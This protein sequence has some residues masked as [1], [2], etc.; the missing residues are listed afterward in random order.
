M[1]M[2]LFIA[3]NLKCRP[4]DHW[5]LVLKLLSIYKVSSGVSMKYRKI[6]VVKYSDDW[7]LAMILFWS[8]LATQS[9]HKDLITCSKNKNIASQKLNN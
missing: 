5:D 8:D 6:S 3:N 7:E 4:Q 2:F 9:V 1:E